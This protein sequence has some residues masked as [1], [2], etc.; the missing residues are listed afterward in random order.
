MEPFDSTGPSEVRPSFTYQLI[1]RRRASSLLLFDFKNRFRLF[2]TSKILAL[3]EAVN[4][5]I[6]AYTII[7]VFIQ[8][9]ETKYV[10]T[11]ILHRYMCFFCLLML[12]P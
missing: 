4:N 1:H 9:K 2:T 7:A 6:A 11:S 3:C 5:L 8:Y 10:I 12:L